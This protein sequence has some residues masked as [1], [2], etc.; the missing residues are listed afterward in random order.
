MKDIVM[1]FEK[2]QRIIAPSMA[3][4]ILALSAEPVKGTQKIFYQSNIY[5]DLVVGHIVL[6]KLTR[7]RGERLTRIAIKHYVLVAV[8]AF[9]RKSG[10]SKTAFEKSRF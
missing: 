1:C 10:F 9:K 8:I 6:P 3:S 5:E 7:S 4:E 2:T